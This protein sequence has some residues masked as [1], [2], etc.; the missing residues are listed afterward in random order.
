MR[1]RIPVYNEDNE[2]E[3]IEV[4]C[5]Y[6]VPATLFVDSIQDSIKDATTD[7]KETVLVQLNCS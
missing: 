7:N 4:R 1:Y 3:Y 5:D 2:V 6:G